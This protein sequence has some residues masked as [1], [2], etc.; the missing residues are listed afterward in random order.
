V[1]KKKKQSRFPQQKSKA[2]Y[3][4]YHQNVPFREHTF[5]VSAQDIQLALA[6][7]PTPE[8]ARSP[9]HPTRDV[10]VIDADSILPATPNPSGADSFIRQLARDIA[11]TIEYVYQ[12]PEDPAP[13]PRN[14]QHILSMPP[15]HRDLWLK[16]VHEEMNNLMSSCSLA[17]VNQSDLTNKPL[18]VMF[19]FVCKKPDEFGRSRLKCRMV[20]RGDQQP[21]STSARWEAPTIKYTVLKMAAITGVTAGLQVAKSDFPAAFLRSGLGGDAHHDEE[22]IFIRI[23]NA[24]GSWTYYRLLKSVYGLRSAPGRWYKT[25]RTWI[26]EFGLKASKHDPCCFSNGRPG[27]SNITICVYVDDCLFIANPDNQRALNSFFQQKIGKITYDIIGK[28]PTPFLGAMWSIDYNTRTITINQTDYIRSIVKYV[29]DEAIAKTPLRPAPTPAPANPLSPHDQ[30]TSDLRYLTLVGM[31]GWVAAVSRP[32][33]LFAYKECARHGHANGEIHMGYAVR[34][35]RYLLGSIEESL[36][37][38]CPKDVK[39]LVLDGWSDAS[40]AECPWTYRSTSA[41]CITIAGSLIH[42]RSLTQRNVAQSS[43]EAEIYAAFETASTLAFLRAILTHI[44]Y[45][46]TSPCNL[47]VD[48]KSTQAAVQRLSLKQQTKHFSV[49]FF[50]LREYI[51]D[52]VI[53]LVYEPTETL[54][55]DMLTKSLPS[56]KHCPHASRA[57]NGNIFPTAFGGLAFCGGESN[58]SNRLTSSSTSSSRHSLTSMGQL[59]VMASALAGLSSEL[60]TPTFGTGSPTFGMG[61]S[62]GGNT[63]NHLSVASHQP[64]KGHSILFQASS[65]AS[66]PFA[67][68]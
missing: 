5:I 29:E 32:D 30:Q 27:Y 12:D 28:T 9:F 19:V 13:V 1:R 25:L 14:F 63:R 38:R 42:G 23:K 2:A 60:L 62:T 7:F 15:R 21:R 33:I 59:V 31:L 26:E 51:Q 4:Q 67:N 37:L 54:I 16:A 46:W 10:Q 17:Q 56:S 50:R 8:N 35:V 20:V 55:A 66:W 39:H 58:R 57:L 41:C 43:C 47:Y 34:I 65:P 64:F 22:I 18:D 45:S 68:L 24:D 48:S 52:K 40:Y 3:K 36:I 6:A 44:G 53:K 61:C 49:K 11:E